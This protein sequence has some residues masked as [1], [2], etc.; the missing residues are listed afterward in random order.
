MVEQRLMRE[1]QAKTVSAL[2][3]ATRA[4]GEERL[5]EQR[6]QRVQQAKFLSDWMEVQAGRDTEMREAAALQR[7]ESAAALSVLRE[8][9]KERDLIQR[10]ERQQLLNA[11]LNSVCRTGN[12]RQGILGGGEQQLLIG[13]N[14]S[15]R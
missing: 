2:M 14:P 15:G 11:L 10:Q 7:A 5:V 12:P 1:Q 13:N 8:D 6:L 4:D 3:E 9:H